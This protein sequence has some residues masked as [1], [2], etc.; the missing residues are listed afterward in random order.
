MNKYGAMTRQGPVS[1]IPK[2]GLA[3]LLVL[4][5]FLL[6][7]SPSVES[8]ELTTR[9]GFQPN[10]IHHAAVGPLYFTIHNT[11]G[12]DGLEFVL[13][14]STGNVAKDWPLQ[15]LQGRMTDIL[16]LPAGTYTLT[17]VNHS[18]WVFNLAVGQ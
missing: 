13:K 9:W 10:A 6:S 12:I 7:G 15:P 1:T 17:V 3:L 18:N 8:V 4:T 2:A 16:D 14:S 5:C 11:T